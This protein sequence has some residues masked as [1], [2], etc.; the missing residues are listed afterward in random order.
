MLGV[1]S[2]ATLIS[3]PFRRSRTQSGWPWFGALLIVML[4]LTACGTA[5]S[6]PNDGIGFGS[7]VTLTG[8]ATPPEIVIEEASTTALASPVS[9]TPAAPE[10]TPPPLSIA[11]YVQAISGIA[12]RRLQLVRADL[13][14]IASGGDDAA[15]ATQYQTELPE[16]QQLLDDMKKL[17]PPDELKTL[18]ANEIT[19]DQQA[20]DAQ[21]QM[22]QGVQTRD[23]ALIDQATETMLNGQ[24]VQSYCSSGS[25]QEMLQNIGLPVGTPNASALMPSAIRDYND[26][27]LTPVN[28]MAHQYRSLCPFLPTAVSDKPAYAAQLKQILPTVS[29]DID[30]LARITPPDGF[31][32]YHQ[33]L[34]AG[35]Q[36]L[37]KSEQLEVQGDEQNNRAILQQG[38]V[39]QAE[40]ELKLLDAQAALS[41]ALINRVTG[42]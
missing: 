9:A 10:G 28:D 8:S 39:A 37:L 38:R 29:Q 4:L 3:A 17:N 11:A 41:A 14:L 31:N 22:I 23:Q 6:T 30:T 12:D 16:R 21:Q 18:Q 24:Q 35:Y 40:G 25:A 7:G 32:Q 15:I 5:D 19:A 20:L 27:I 1:A 13:T 42:P 34:L 2:R 36:K 26:A 33:D